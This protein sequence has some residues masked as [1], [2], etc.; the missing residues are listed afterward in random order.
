MSESPRPPPPKKKPV[1]RDKINHEKR[2][3]R[4]AHRVEDHAAHHVG[5]HVGRWAAVLEVTFLFRLRGAGDADGCASVGHA[6]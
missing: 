1:P 2:N 4:E 3:K 5:V 6:V